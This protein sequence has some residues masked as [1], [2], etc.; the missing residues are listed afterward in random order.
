MNF[1]VR[2]S[3]VAVV[4]AIFTFGQFKPVWDS[5]AQIPSTRFVMTS[6]RVSVSIFR[7][8]GWKF[9]FF[10]SAVAVARDPFVDQINHGL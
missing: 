5:F 7:P 8:I 6:F 9:L 10:F 1:H 2:T 3:I 4:I